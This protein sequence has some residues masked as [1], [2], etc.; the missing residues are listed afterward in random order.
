MS[1][2]MVLQNGV[3]LLVDEIGASGAVSLGV[4]VNLGSR[5]ENRE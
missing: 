3:T 1:K 4:W 2:K 5:D